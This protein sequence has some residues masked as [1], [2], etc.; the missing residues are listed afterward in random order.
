MEKEKENSTKK[1]FQLGSV[2][3]MSFAHFLHDTYSS[4]LAPILPMLIEKFSMNYTLAGLLTVFQRIPSL[5]NPFV[6]LIADKKSVRYFVTLTPAI[7]AI[8][9]SLLGAAPNYIILAILLLVMGVSSA[10]FHVP[11]PVIIKKVS[12]YRV[13]KGMS[14]YMLGGEIARTI[15]PLIIIGAVSLWGLEGTYKLIPF[16]LVGSLILYLKV[17]KINISKNDNTNIEIVGIK[18]TF[19]NHLNFFLVIA[20]ILFTSSVLK[21]G[22]TSFIPTYFV[23]VKHESS[24]IA[25]GALSLLQFAGMLGA[26]LSGTLSDRLGRTK[27]LLFIYIFTPI[28]MWLFITFD[29]IFQIPLLLILGFFSIASGPVILALVQETNSERPAFI[30]GIYM[31]INFIVSSLTVFLF[32]FFS[33][34]MGLE[35]AFKLS[36]VISILAIPLTFALKKVRK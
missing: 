18:Q 34:W 36:A 8:A 4:F 13:G 2:L 30:N 20:G 7:T 31:T 22:L 23:H 16:G 1:R 35:N 10:I 12:G 3:T 6:G 5:I 21:S 27:T 19:K 15:G 9:M 29:G 32:G 28:A 24:W 11:S 25:A 33:D 14:F 17:Q 26:F